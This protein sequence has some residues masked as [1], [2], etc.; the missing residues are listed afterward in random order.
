LTSQ[1]PELD[2]EQPGVLL[3]YLRQRRAI[4]PLEEPAIEVLDGGVS[5]RVVLVRRTNGEG[6]VLKQS[7]PKLRVA[8]DWF[9][10]PQRVH[11]EALALRWLPELGLRVPALEF[12]D[13]DHHLIAMDAVPEPHENWKTMLL[14]G[15]LDMRHIDQWAQMLAT[16]HVQSRNRI[17]EIEV[18]FQDRTFFESLRIEPYYLY[19]AGQVPQAH[20]F[21]TEV[22]EATRTNRQCLVHGDFSPKNVLVY[23]DRLVLLDHEVA[24]FGDPSFDIGFSMTHLLSKAHHLQNHRAHFQKAA[25]RYWD[26]YWDMVHAEGW[27]DG[28][29]RRAV[30]SILACLLARVAGRSQLEYL[31]QSERANQQRVVLELMARPPASVDELISSFVAGVS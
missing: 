30:N 21:L 15:R 19:T 6:W 5:S 11:R 2:I 9:S 22:V 10:D 16:L 27:S 12:E 24:H 25:H 26:I 3:P 29:E 20:P 4:G 14:G 31:D 18:D 7:L 28:L 23:M 13:F 17:P 1:G 8:V